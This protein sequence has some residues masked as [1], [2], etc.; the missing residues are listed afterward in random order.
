M[1][2]AIFCISPGSIFPLT[3][4]VLRSLKAIGKESAIVAMIFRRASPDPWIGAP[5]ELSGC[6]TGG[7]LNLIRVG[8]ALTGKRIATEKAP[9]ALLE[10]EPA[11]SFGNEDV[12]DAWM[13]FQPGAGLQTVVTGE[14]IGDDEEVARGIVGFDVGEQSNV[15]RRVARGGTPGQFF[16]I[17][18]P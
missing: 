6:D 13:T 18:H 15:V 17:A 16:A 5:I 2:M 8:K 12:M 9:P 7:L 11:S 1:R 10:I 14:I 3:T 4:V